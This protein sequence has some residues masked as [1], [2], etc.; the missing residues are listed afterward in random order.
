MNCGQLASEAGRHE[1][2][3]HLRLDGIPQIR[4]Q[5]TAAMEG[6][7]SMIDCILELLSKAWAN[8]CKDESES[9]PKHMHVEGSDKIRVPG[10]QPTSNPETSERS[11]WLKNFPR[12]QLFS[13]F[14]DGD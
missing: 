10:P 3:F 12:R 13:A 5:I 8:E 1:S 2:H 9:R 4:L 11:Q 14:E 6:Q 7:V